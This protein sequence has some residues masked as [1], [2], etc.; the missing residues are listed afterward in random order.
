MEENKLERTKTI[1][2]KGES[3]TFDISNVS[4]NDYLTIMNEK[5]RITNG[6]YSKIATSLLMSA[7]NASNIIDM[8]AT[9]RVLKPE[10]ENSINGKDFSKLN[11]FDAKE[12]I[13]VYVKEFFPWYNAWM[14]KFESPFGSE[15][16][17]N[18]EGDKK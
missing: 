18:G 8:I 4:I 9:F 1:T 17:G 14:G 11:I 6:S 7:Y 10:I 15:I 5:I 3:F 13:D 16:D 2:I 12:L